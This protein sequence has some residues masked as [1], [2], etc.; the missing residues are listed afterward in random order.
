MAGFA[1]FAAERYDEGIEWTR[2]GLEENPDL[3]GVYRVLAANC[4]QA[5]TL[6]PIV[7][8][9]HGAQSRCR[10][11]SVFQNIA[12]RSLRRRVRHSVQGVA[13]GLISILVVHVI[14]LCATRL[15]WLSD[16]FTTRA[17][18]ASAPRE[19]VQSP[20]ELVIRQPLPTE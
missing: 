14:L 9:A 18:W 3:P 1:A 10:G 17:R 15:R 11:P 2:R 4:G 16:R 19:A 20:T 6:P 13:I 12:S 7:P 5:A 8:D